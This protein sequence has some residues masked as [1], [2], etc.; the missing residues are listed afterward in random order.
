M[1]G[2]LIAA[3]RME[4]HAILA[5]LRE[6]I[7][8]RRLEELRRLLDLYADQPPVGAELDAVLAGPPAHAPRRV[9]T[10]QPVILLHGEARSVEVA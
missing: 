10:P 7:T 8:F 4:E 1:S 5:E 9:S 6:S 2:S 3:L